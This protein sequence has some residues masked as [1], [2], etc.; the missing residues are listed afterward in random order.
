[1]NWST[2]P[3]AKIIVENQCRF[4]QID[5]DSINFDEHLWQD[6]YYWSESQESDFKEWFIDFLLHNRYARKEICNMSMIKSKKYLN[7]VYNDWIF[8]YGFIIKNDEI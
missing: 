7:K 8:A 6:K 4:A 2:I 3:Y 5:F 1:M